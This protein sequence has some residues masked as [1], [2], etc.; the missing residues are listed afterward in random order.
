MS[1]ELFVILR[2]AHIWTFCSALKLAVG[3][4]YVL[5]LP[6]SPT[7][8]AQHKIQF[9]NPLYKAMTYGWLGGGDQMKI[10]RLSNAGH[11]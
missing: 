5:S 3:V 9:I 10:S 8:E 7:S 6:L 11:L 1:V 2:T 4:G